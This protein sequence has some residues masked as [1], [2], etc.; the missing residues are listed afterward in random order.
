MGNDMDFDAKARL[1]R[2]IE[3]TRMLSEVEKVIPLASQT[4]SKS[5]TQYPPKISPLFLSRSLGCKSWDIDGNEY[6]D[7]VSSLAAVTLGYGDLEV[8]N[9]VIEQLANGVTL[10]LPG[11]L[12]Y[13]VATLISDL[14]PSIEK[15]RFAKTGSDATAGAIRLARAFTRRDHVLIG[16]YHGWQDWYIGSTSMNLGVPKAVSEL[17]HK[18]SVNNIV[19]IENLFAK[20]NGKIAAI[21]LEP[22]SYES[23]T[24]DF[25]QYLRKRSSELGIVLIFDETVTGFRVAKDGAQGYLGI[26]PD[27]TTFGKGIANGFPLSALGGRSEIMDLMDR[28]FF[29]GTFGGE[30]L[31]LAAAKVVLT[32]VK[33]ENVIEK[34]AQ[35]GSILHLKINQIL[36]DLDFSGLSLSGHPSWQFLIWDD[37]CFRN[38]PKVK[39]LFL[40]EMFFNGVLILGSHNITTSHDSDSFN[41]VSTAYRKTLQLIKSAETHDSYE[42]YLLVDPLKPLFRVR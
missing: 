8:N 15:V 12:E 34:L 2:Y 21:I 42:K 26:T 1:E 7:L 36:R 39:T 38:L 19:E 5:R 40:Q 20:L 11:V 37:N 10:S 22:I 23:P 35:N 13:E 16:G 33:N 30:L 25:I 6:V 27:L 14:I 9:A 3:S 32:K 18:F 17:T 29:S 41:L 24:V 31:S 28:I 4:F